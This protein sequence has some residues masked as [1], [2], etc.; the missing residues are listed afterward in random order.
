MRSILGYMAIAGVV[1]LVYKGIKEV[2][3]KPTPKLKDK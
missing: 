2:K 1:Y 3:S